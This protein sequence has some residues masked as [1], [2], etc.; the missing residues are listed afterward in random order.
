[1]AS[2]LLDYAC[3]LHKKS[4]IFVVTQV[5]ESMCGK[6]FSIFIEFAVAS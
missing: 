4:F 6:A 1:M 2:R 5:T 3:S